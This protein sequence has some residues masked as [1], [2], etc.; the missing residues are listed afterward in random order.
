[1]SQ[2]N[3]YECVETFKGWWTSVDILGSHQL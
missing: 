2:R 1:M 3:V